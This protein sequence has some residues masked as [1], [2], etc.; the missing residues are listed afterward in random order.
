MG[1]PQKREVISAF[2]FF[3]FSSVVVSEL[4]PTG[5]TPRLLECN[6]IIIRYV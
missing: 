5:A 3:F 1:I 6:L 4:V 2:F